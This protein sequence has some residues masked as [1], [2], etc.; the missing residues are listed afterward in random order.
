MGAALRPSCRGAER[1][2]LS[3]RQESCRKPE[4]FRQTWR[5]M[6][7]YGAVGLEMG[8]SVALGA[9]FGLW[10]DRKLG[11]RPICTLLGLLFGLGAA[12]RALW[13]VV[14]QAEA[15]AEREAREARE[16]KS[17]GGAPNGGEREQEE[18][19]TPPGEKEPD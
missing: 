16:A 10:L 12:A 9:G 14:K 4:G 19:S 5:S 1:K 7:T 3:D 15:E 13:R 17:G 8:I 11:T 2:A 18:G 6:R